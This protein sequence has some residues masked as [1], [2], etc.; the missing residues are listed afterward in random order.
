MTEQTWTP[1]RTEALVVLWN[2]DVSSKKIG[3]ALGLSK[4]AVL[5]KAHRLRLKPRQAPVEPGVPGKNVFPRTPPD[6]PCEICGTPIVAQERGW[7]ICG[8]CTWKA[9]LGPDYFKRRAA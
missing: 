9:I 5:G 2:A 8:F 3:H 7:R 6:V 1:E 4:S